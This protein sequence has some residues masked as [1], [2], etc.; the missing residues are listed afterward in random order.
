MKNFSFISYQK[1][2]NLIYN[3]LSYILN[4]KKLHSKT[5]PTFISLETASICNLHC[6]ECAIGQKRFARK[7]FM[8]IEVF[9]KVIDEI[10]KYTLNVLLYFQ[11]E[12]LLHPNIITMIKYANK[13][14]LYTY[15]S[16]NAQNLNKNISIQIVKSQLRHIIIS[17]DGTTQQSYEQYRVG[18][19][20]AKAVEAIKFLKEEKEI[21]H[22]I[23]P[24]IEVQ[25]VVFK[26]NENEIETIKHFAKKWGANVVTIKSA[27][28]YDYKEKTEIIPSKQ[29]YSRY[30]QKNGI[31][32]LKKKIKNKCFRSW[33]GVVVNSEGEVL[34]C[35]FDKQSNFVFGNVQYSS[36]KEIFHNDKA[37]KF[38]QQIKEN[39]NF[40][41]IC[42]NC[43]E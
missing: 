24:K 39:R 7:P 18:G 11:G 29:K 13:K 33:A 25:F 27:Q 23:F 15:L 34:P 36:I 8:D 4:S 28:I 43:T 31:W 12:P 1:I 35:C 20:L 30:I 26:H 10:Q 19:S 32:Q 37:T 17:I 16:T 22:S 40:F 42:T 14:K 41:D 3:Y 9:K 6:P 5:Y 2:K 21:Q 38:R